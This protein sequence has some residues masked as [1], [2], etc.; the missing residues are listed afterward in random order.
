[1]L[2]T[3]ALQL[4]VT[5]ATLLLFVFFCIWSMGDLFPYID[6]KLV[7]NCMSESKVHVLV[8]WPYP[9]NAITEYLAVNDQSAMFI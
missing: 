1:M 8:M 4:F 2:I 9:V 6:C 3:D 5:I 7:Q